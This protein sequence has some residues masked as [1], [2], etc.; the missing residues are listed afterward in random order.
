MIKLNIIWWNN[1]QKKDLDAR[2]LPR[3][4]YPIK[5]PILPGKSGQQNDN[6]GQLGQ[7]GNQLPGDRTSYHKSS[8]LTG[9]LVQFL[10]IGML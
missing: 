5:C 8:H 4:K 1:W 2:L 9:Q 6:S 3:T 7:L 10:P